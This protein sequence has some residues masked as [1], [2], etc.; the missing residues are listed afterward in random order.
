MLAL[1]GMAPTIDLDDQGRPRWLF[2]RTVH[3]GCSRA[4]LA[5]HGKFADAFGGDGC[6]VKLGC[7]GPVVSCNVPVRGW[8]NGIGGCPNV[9]GICIACTSA[10]FPDRFLP[11]M[12]PA[13]LGV[14]AAQR[15][16]LHLWPGAQALP[17]ARHEAHLRSRALVAATVA[18]SC[19]TGY[20]SRW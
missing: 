6:L 7:M 20:A 8:V 12:E 18:P 19:T 4:G 15:R 11:F 9:G 16:A 1:G 17:Q 3:E 5:E 14:L 2:E 10:G 13:R